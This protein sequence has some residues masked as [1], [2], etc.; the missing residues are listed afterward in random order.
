MSH[1]FFYKDVR[2]KSAYPDFEI[3]VSFL[4]AYMKLIWLAVEA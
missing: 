1:V 2:E 3:N 4:S